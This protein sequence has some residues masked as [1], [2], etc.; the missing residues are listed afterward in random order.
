MIQTDDLNRPRGGGDFKDPVPGPGHLLLV[1]IDPHKD[2][3]VAMLGVQHDR[4]IL[5]I[6]ADG[7]Y[8]VVLDIVDFLLVDSCRSWIRKKL[9]AELADLFLLGSGQGREGVE[10]LS[11]ESH[12][13]H[14]TSL[15]KQLPKLLI[16]Q[17]G[18]KEHGPALLLE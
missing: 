10:E 11:G 9:R 18:R 7:P 8:L 2:M 17:F 4:P 14:G 13:G 6:D 12:G 3:H 5:L 15:R 1:V 16:S